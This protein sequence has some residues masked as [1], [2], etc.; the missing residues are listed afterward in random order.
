M[1]MDSM[2][3]LAFADISM[4]WLEYFKYIEL[5]IYIYFRYSEDIRL[6]SAFH[7]TNAKSFIRTNTLTL[8]MYFLYVLLT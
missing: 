3:E 6:H 5:K 7:N 2:L 8:Q 1:A 4:K